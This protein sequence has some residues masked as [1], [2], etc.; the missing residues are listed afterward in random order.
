MIAV[1]VTT[2]ASIQALDYSTGSWDVDLYKRGATY[3]VRG[4]S[5]GGDTY[6]F[7]RKPTLNADIGALI[8]QTT[9]VV[10]QDGRYDFNT[11]VKNGY[12]SLNVSGVGGVAAADSP[13]S[14]SSDM[15]YGHWH[16]DYRQGTQIRLGFHATFGDGSDYAWAKVNVR[17]I[18]P[19]TSG[20]ST[21]GGSTGG[22]STGGGSTGGGSTGGAPAAAVNSGFVWG[23]VAQSDFG[24]GNYH[25]KTWTPSGAFIGTVYGDANLS[26]TSSQNTNVGIVGWR[27]LLVA[28][29]AGTYAFSTN[30]SNA[31]IW[32]RIN[33]QGVAL[34]YTMTVVQGQQVKIDCVASFGAGWNASAGLTVGWQANVPPANTA[35]SAAVD[36]GFV[37]GQVAQSD[38]VQNNY[39]TK[40]WTPSGTF[41]GTVYGDASLSRTSSQNSNVG[42]VGWRRLLVAPADGTY[43]F[44][45]NASN[46]QVWLRINGQGVRMP[47]TM[48]VTQGQQ[49]KID[50][51]AW[52]GSG[53]NASAA[54]SFSWQN[55]GFDGNPLADL[56][57]ETCDAIGAALIQATSEHQP[58]NEEENILPFELPQVYI[59][60]R[61]SAV[62]AWP[63]SGSI[64][65]DLGEKL[66]TPESLSI[67]KLT[68]NAKIKGDFTGRG[69]FTTLESTP[70]DLRGRLGFEVGLKGALNWPGV[71][72]F[73]KVVRRE[74]I[75]PNRNR[76]YR[77]GSKITITT[78]LSGNILGSG[79]LVYKGP[80]Y[81]GRLSFA[82]SIE[83]KGK[84]D[85]KGTFAPG[86][87]EVRD[88]NLI[89]NAVVPNS[90]RRHDLIKVSV[91]AFVG[92]TIGGSFGCSETW[93]DLANSDVYVGWN[94][95]TLEW[96]GEITFHVGPF[97]YK[98][99]PTWRKEFWKG[100][101]KKVIWQTDLRQRVGT[102]FVRGSSG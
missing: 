7:T 83:G 12:C 90:T 69:P 64:E 68:A 35:P 58:E 73:E 86:F 99:T 27:R 76:E 5:S 38:Y 32:L 16:G 2:T 33:G 94:A 55:S 22:G 88:V 67:F 91:G 41:I 10:P 31:Q 37:W 50:C 25:T 8:G 28:P 18:G 29:A 96:G 54:L 44:S 59:D 9:Y 14:G 1:L 75:A 89:T 57:K 77:I 51:V 19:M 56:D 60:S 26:R 4:E 42:I 15:R 36:A 87:V 6:E 101:G 71:V 20:G 3:T 43:S 72:N 95:F 53:W 81:A 48:T 47:H 102:N 85:V 80:R 52:F 92:P 93:G 45:A 30:A 49:V 39:H 61:E 70:F 40:T 11:G 82:G 98:Y 84:L 24:Q 21:G 34:P 100:T 17:R 23:E 79:A 97:N 74:R 13:G 78:E 46:A 66:L 62:G 65:A 63:W